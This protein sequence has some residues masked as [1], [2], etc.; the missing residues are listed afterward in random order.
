MEKIWLQKYPECV[1]KN[2]NPDAFASI[3]DLFEKTAEKFRR[4]PALYQMGLKMSYEKLDKKSKDFAAYLQQKLGLKKGDR[5]AIMMPNSVQYIVAML[6]A[7]RAGL[8]V[9]NVNP[10]YTVREVVHQIKDANA[11]V[12]LVLANFAHVVEKALPQTDLEQ[13]IV[14]EV[15]DMFRFIKSKMI[16]FVT[17]RIKK[18]VPNY[19]RAGIIPFRDALSQGKRLRFAK[20]D[21]R[22]GDLAFLQYTGGTTGISK[23]AMLSHRNMIANVEQCYA[24]M[25]AGGLDLGK[26]IV[27]TALP[28]YHIFSLLVN[29]FSFLKIGVLNVLVMN[30]TDIAGFIRELSKH[31]FTIFT[32]VNTLFKALLRHRN[33]KKLNFSALK[34]TI[35]GGMA[36]HSSVADQ[37]H[38]MTGKPIIEAY[39]LTEASP[40]VSCNLLTIKKYN[41]SIGIPL[42]STE[43][44][45]ID[46]QTGKEL[47]IGEPGELCVQGP[48]V[49][50]GYWNRPEETAQVISSDGWLH[51]GDIAEMNADGLITIVDRKKD[52]IVVSGYNVYPNEVEEVLSEHPD[53]LEVAVIGEQSE[54]TGE[55]IKAY[56]V[57]KGKSLNRETLMAFC[58]ERLTSYKIPKRFEFC[59]TLPKSNVGKI[60]RRV[61]REERFRIKHAD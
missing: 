13:V 59:E 27:I 4:K 21:V 49:M 20:V 54:K 3:N 60:L 34:M 23:G 35:G 14:T 18:M 40:A 5:F 33:F 37:W 56:I 57:R 10:L 41:K 45:I 9:V 12:I 2:I 39:G 31:D 50:Q 1:P 11:K 43:I 47:S 51:T 7:L 38:E 29:C 58:R 15:G 28:M 24:W 19:K 61:L 55:V 48:Q 53:I 16:N 17:K 52:M 44:K 42:P 25:S 8:V 6:G 46:T 26:E 22:G 30:P 36:V 32:G